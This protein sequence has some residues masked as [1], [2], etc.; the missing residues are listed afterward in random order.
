MIAAFSG[1]F[2]FLFFFKGTGEVISQWGY[3]DGIDEVYKGGL[4]D[5]YSDDALMPPND[6]FYQVRATGSFIFLL[7]QPFSFSLYVLF[8]LFHRCKIQIFLKTT[9]LICMPKLPCTRC[10][11]TTACPCSSL[12][13]L[14]RSIRSLCRL[15]K[16]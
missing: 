14:W 5:W 10:R 12:G 1:V 8:L 11:K 4:P 16:M 3:N 9:G 15:L 7:S 13:C 6:Q 2:T